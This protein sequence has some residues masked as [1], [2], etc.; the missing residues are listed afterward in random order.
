MAKTQNPQY[1][2]LFGNS[3]LTP[4][5]VVQQQ[6]A[7]S[8]KSA[9]EAFAGSDAPVKAGATFGAGLGGMLRGALMDSGMLSK[10]PEVEAA[11]RNQILKEDILKTAKEKGIDITNLENLADLTASKAMDMK[12]FATA[13][14]AVQLKLVL[15]AQKRGAALQGSQVTKNLAGAEKDLAEAEKAKAETKA[16]PAINAA[17]LDLLKNQAHLAKVKAAGLQVLTSLKQNDPNRVKV[18]KWN[19]IIADV[20]KNGGKISPKQRKILD[21]Y[22]KVD[23]INRMLGQTL[24]ATPEAVAPAAAPD[25]ASEHFDFSASP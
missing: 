25:E 8:I 20:E 21:E 6:I 1:V 15:Q 22:S 5:Q 13:S 12:D 17:K 4:A 10:D 16:A 24:G 23:P 7:K 11:E 9:Q 19:E 3:T 14:K 18:Q 2:D